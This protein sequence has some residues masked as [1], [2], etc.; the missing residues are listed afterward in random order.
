MEFPFAFTAAVLARGAGSPMRNEP[1]GVELPLVLPDRM[2]RFRVGT[3]AF[4]GLGM[5]EL[6]GRVLERVG[7]GTPGRMDGGRGGVRLGVAAIFFLEV[8]IR[9]FQS[10]VFE[11]KCLRDRTDLHLH[12]AGLDVDAALD[13]LD[14]LVAVAFLNER[15]CGSSFGGMFTSITR[16]LLKRVLIPVSFTSTGTF[17]VPWV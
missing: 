9:S 1:D 3:V 14:T 12:C 4:T 16:T 15:Y 5:P 17:L 10:V 8:G 11:G 13:H 7:T 6:G 2:R